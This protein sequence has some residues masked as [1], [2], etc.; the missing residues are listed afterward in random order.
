MHADTPASRWNQ[1]PD[2][3]SDTNVADNVYLRALRE[4]YDSLKKSIE[5]L[6]Q[7]A[8]EAKRD[9]TNEELRSVIEQGEKAKALFTQ[10]E[11][12]TDIEL[13]NAKVAEMNAKVAE[14]TSRSFTA[15]GDPDAVAGAGAAFAG[16]GGTNG[17]GFVPVGGARTS[18]R[19]PG[20]YTRDSKF[21]FVG[22]Q[23]R[24]AQLGDKEAVQRLTQ[25]TN[26]MRDNVHL[27]D[28]LGTTTGGGVGLIPPVWLADQYAG[29]LH[30][31]LRVAAQ[32]RQVPWA[33]PYPW[34]IPVAS[35][36]VVLSTLAEG[37][38]GSIETDP[39][40]TTITVLPSNISGY[41]EVSRQMLEAANP[42]VDSIIWGDMLGAFY[43]M[44]ETNTIAAIEATAGI[45]VV[46]V[47]F[48]STADM[49][50]GILDGIAAIEDNGGGD[51]DLFFSRRVRWHQY[52][53]LVD[54]TGRPIVVN[55]QSYGPTNAIGMGGA[56]GGFRNAVVGELESLPV[57]TSPT[58]NASRGYVVNSQELLFSISPPMQFS[59]EQPAGPQL[60]RIGV[61]G[62]MAAVPNR[63]P[64]SITRVHFSAF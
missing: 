19:D 26:A 62:Y 59:F 63:R 14:A 5:G 39:T 2:F 50:G 53:K 21:S 54:T 56:V 1:I 6:Q 45:N 7:R 25:H 15:T 31:R 46:T 64:K 22:D 38:A 42:A 10:I 58:V 60:I 37:G 11:D 49:R 33:G 55:N 47:L 9:L 16:Q 61:W 4:Q 40:Y 29:I 43:D 13:R 36:P 20:F 24:A 32:L 57:V 28:V 35:N 23:F 44:A 12:L 52:L 51:G 30:R 27:R 18:D 48:Q 17:D 41:S 8:A 34:T 3:G